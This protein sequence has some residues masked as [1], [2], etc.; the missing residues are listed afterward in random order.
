MVENP[1]PC[2]GVTYP[3]GS[4]SG[5]APPRTRASPPS[6]RKNRRVGS[7][8]AGP[9]TRR[10]ATPHQWLDPW[11]PDHEDDIFATR[12]RDVPW[13]ALLECP[14]TPPA[15][16]TPVVLAALPAGK[17]LALWTYIPA[18]RRHPSPFW[19][20]TDL[21]WQV[22]TPREWCRLRLPWDPAIQGPSHDSRFRIP[23]TNIP[24]EPPEGQHVIPIRRAYIMLH[25]IEITRVSDSVKIPH[26]DV[27]IALDAAS[28]AWSVDATLLGPDALA[29]VEPTGSDPMILQVSVNGVDWHFLVED[30]TETLTFGQRA[31]AISGRGLTAL[32]A[33]PYQLPRT[34][35]ETSGW[36]M[37]QLVD[38]ELPVTG[39]SATWEPEFAPFIP[40]GAWTYQQLTP[41][42]AIAAVA[43]SA[44]AVIVPAKAEQSLVIRP[45]YPVLPWDYAEATPD[46]VAQAGRTRIT[47]QYSPPDQANAIYIYGGN[48]SGILARVYRTGSAGDRYA[49]EIRDA[50]CVDQ[51]VARLRGRREL[52]KQVSPPAVR[53]IELPFDNNDFILP[54]IG[55][56]VE[57]SGGWGTSRGTVSSIALAVSVGQKG[58]VSVRQTLGFGDGNENVW[59]RFLSLLPYDPLLVGEII[60]DNGDGTVT[61]EHNDGGIQRVLGAGTV[62]GKVYVRSGRVEGEAPALTSYDI[63]V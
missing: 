56:L 26:A 16:T 28:W 54:D 55:H 12:N 5:P 47:R 51:A 62:G 41:I 24:D 8:C 4:T 6:N 43:Q 52:A 11:T 33:A 29:L 49:S 61:V 27:R 9:W 15:L 18:R 37:P 7:G 45:R 53:A 2:R 21:P 35:T 63:E 58:E 1:T 36:T 17:K 44:G 30:W 25:D 46:L 3:A 31:V 60:T 13:P 38:N 22:A 20:L 14:Y 50:L 59:S 10:V 48:V 42:Q 19:Q 32:L 39:W 34:Y 23:I 57:V 40:A